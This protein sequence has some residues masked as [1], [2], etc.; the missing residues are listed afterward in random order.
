MII[1]SKEKKNIDV[2]DRV[3]IVQPAFNIDD[4]Q[5]VKSFIN[6][7]CS[8]PILSKHFIKKKTEKHIPLPS[9]HMIL[10]YGRIF[11]LKLIRGMLYRFA[12]RF[13][14]KFG[15][16]IIYVLEPKF[17]STSEIKL[18]LITAYKNKANDIHDTLNLENYI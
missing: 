12:I 9:I 6:R 3:H 5:K 17:V 14:D 2:V 13:D 1:M 4:V 18:T 11:E 8:D 15:S 16:S 7:N 10:K